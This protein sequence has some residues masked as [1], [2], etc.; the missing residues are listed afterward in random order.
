MKIVFTGGGSGGHFYPIIAVSQELTRLLEKEEFINTQMYY[1]SN[2][3][4][5][6]ELLKQNH[7]I[8]KQNKTGKLR[9]YFSPLNLFDAVFTFFAT[10][11]AVFLLF[12]IY[13][14]VVFSK[15]AY[16]SFPIT[17]AAR[18]LGIP[19][20]IHESDSVPGRANKIAGKFAKRVALSY[21]EAASYFS[22]EKIALTGNPIRQELL[23][24]PKVNAREMFGLIEDKPLIFITGGSQGAQLLNDVLIRVGPKILDTYQV[25]HQVGSQNFANFQATMD[26]ILK[27]HPYQN[28]YKIFPYLDTQQ[29]SAI[30]QTAN[31]I[32]SRGG[33]SIFEIAVWG[34]PSIIVPISKTNGD[35]QRKN[36]YAYART[37]ACSVIDENN[38]TPNLFLS[39]IDRICNNEEVI[40]RMKK[41]TK[42]FAKKDAALKI[43]IEILG[44]LKSHTVP[45]NTKQ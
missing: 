27:N 35:H 36:A 1:I 41:G 5:N 24:V 7:L 19:V 8:Y 22:A 43:A 32:I 17:T 25:I 30:G 4:Y 23:D 28:Q 44:V 42:I 11:R 38:L 45:E 37:G 6:E 12:F 16:P 14:D 18:L 13:P 20:I 2:A 15:G 29:M 21:S 3:P 9:V 39:E 10:I 40:T 34:V 31:L 26:I 33:S